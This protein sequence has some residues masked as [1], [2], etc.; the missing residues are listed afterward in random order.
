MMTG[1]VPSLVVGSMMED[2]NASRWNL[3]DQFVYANSLPTSFLVRQTPSVMFIQE[4]ITTLSILKGK[5]LVSSK[6]GPRSYLL[7]CPLSLVDIY[8]HS[9]VFANMG[10]E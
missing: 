10:E 5:L 1:L 4:N 6:K 7:N 2:Q 8:R 9:L 3:T